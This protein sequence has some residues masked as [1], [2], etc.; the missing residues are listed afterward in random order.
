MNY[1]EMECPHEY[2]L[3]DFCGAVT[4]IFCNHH[5]GFDRCYCGWTRSGTGDGYDELLSLGEDIE[6]F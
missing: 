6:P 2:E 4:C 1:E 3:S 5:K